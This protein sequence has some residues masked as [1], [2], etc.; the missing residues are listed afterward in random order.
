MKIGIV[1]TTI[2]EGRNGIN[3]A[4]WVLEN[5]KK[6]NEDNVEYSLVDLKDFNLP[7]MG[8]QKEED[9]TNISNWKSTMGSFDGFIFIQSEYNHAPSG[10]FKNALDYLNVELKEKVIGFV[11]YGGIGGGRA[12][13]QIKLTVS[14]FSA[15]TTGVAVNLLINTDFVNMNEFKPKDYQI[16]ALNNLLDETVRWTKAF[17]TIRN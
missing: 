16:T 15:I 8:M 1:T 7:I 12:I 9:L 14:T 17:K 4:N 3:V 2:R 6:R 10:V 5:A 11:G 13:E